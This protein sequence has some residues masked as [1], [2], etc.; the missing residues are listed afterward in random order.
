MKDQIRAEFE[1]E[2][3][4]PNGVTFDGDHYVADPA[5]MGSFQNATIW[6]HMYRGW[7]RRQET[8]VV[9]VPSITYKQNPDSESDAELRMRIRFIEALSNS[10]IRPC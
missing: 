4:L 8:M 7:K 1:Q 10:G 5:V 6:S 3:P 9:Q 2:F